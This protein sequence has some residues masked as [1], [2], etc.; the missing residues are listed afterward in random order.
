MTKKDFLSLPFALGIGLMV[1]VIVIAVSLA[2]AEP[3]NGYQPTK[4]EAAIDQCW[5]LIVTDENG[6]SRHCRDIVYPENC[7]G[8]TGRDWGS[9][10]DDPF[11]LD[12]YYTDVTEGNQ[13]EHAE[14][15]EIIQ[16]GF[17]YHCKLSDSTGDCYSYE[18][19]YEN[20]LGESV[21]V[22]YGFV[23]F[24]RDECDAAW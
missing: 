2:V 23:S 10:W 11:G 17:E 14:G 3:C 8:S 9:V 13:T 7:E 1:S 21:P 16:C 15:G 4:I 6:Y 20:H 18:K 19:V 5:G 12:H 24:W 22:E